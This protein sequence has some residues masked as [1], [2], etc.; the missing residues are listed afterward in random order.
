MIVFVVVC[1]AVRCRVQSSSLSSVVSRPRDTRLLGHARCPHWTFVV[2]CRWRRTRPCTGV[3]P[4]LRSSQPGR[5]GGRRWR[6]RWPVRE[7]Q[8]RIAV[9]VQRRTDWTSLSAAAAAAAATRCNVTSRW[10][11]AAI[12]VDHLYRISTSVFF[13]LDALSASC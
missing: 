8:H 9:I 4:V 1:R 12:S 10:F 13:P 3:L 7:L 6:W 2:S 5:S 11:P